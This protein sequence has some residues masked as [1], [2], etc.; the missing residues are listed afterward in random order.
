MFIPH[1]GKSADPHSNTCIHSYSY[2]HIHTQSYSYAPQN[3]GYLTLTHSSSIVPSISMGISMAKFTSARH[4]PYLPTSQRPSS[5][6]LRSPQQVRPWRLHWTQ[7]GGAPGTTSSAGPFGNLTP[8]M[9]RTSW[10]NG[11][12]EW[13]KNEMSIGLDVDLRS[14]LL[15]ESCMWIMQ[16]R[17]IAC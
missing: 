16:G 5:T 7:T 2:H 9:L 11:V 1:Y 12:V 6:L 10:I 13:R 17:S 8:K 14:D 3:L 4:L 15:N